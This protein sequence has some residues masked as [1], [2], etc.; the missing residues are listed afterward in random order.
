MPVLAASVTAADVA[1]YL[2]KWDGAK[3]PA[4]HGAP[5]TAQADD[6][7]PADAAVSRRLQQEVGPK[8]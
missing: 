5:G 2:G 6:D 7:A 3:P 4:A 8:M 1:L